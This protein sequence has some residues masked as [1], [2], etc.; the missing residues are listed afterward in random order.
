M[1]ISDKPDKIAVVIGASGGIGK[2][3]A[4]VLRSQGLTT[5]GL[6]RRLPEAERS[7]PCDVRDERSVA[8]AFRLVLERFGA[9]SVLVNCAGIASTGD[10]ASLSLE[11]WD[12]VLR[13]NVTGMY[14]TCKYA[15]PSMRQQR[16]GRIVNVSSIAGRAV[17]A[18][19]SIAYTA[20]KHA[21]IG[22]TKQL[23]VQ[24][25]KDGITVNCVCPSETETDMLQQHVPAE[26]R[27]ALAASHPM[28]RLARPE[29]IAQTI[30]FLASEVASYLNGAVIDVNGGR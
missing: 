28:G 5:I 11:E 4:E 6:S 22:L 15:L 8:A 23:A 14:L 19:G 16:Y 26:R 29:E 25:A 17:S 27:Q 1:S 10:A 2:V 30:A 20:S 9:V 18:S 3:T 13:T 7:L 24:V 21:V 12:T